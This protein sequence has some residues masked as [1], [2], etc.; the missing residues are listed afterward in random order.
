MTSIFSH[1]KNLRSSEDKV[2]V[3]LVQLCLTLCK[4]MDCSLPGSSVH[5]ILQ[6]RILVWVAI[7]F[8]RGSFQHRDQ[9][10]VSCIAGRFLTIKSCPNSGLQN[11]GKN[12]SPTVAGSLFH[13]YCGVALEYSVPQLDRAI[14]LDSRRAFIEYRMKSCIQLQSSIIL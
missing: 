2:N 1:M 3:L 7:P 12:S 13:L 14:A 4:S 10:W 6:T 9:T 5:G 8:S 11:Q